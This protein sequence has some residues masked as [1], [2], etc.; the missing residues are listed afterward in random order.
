MEIT[1]RYPFRSLDEFAQFLIQK[2]VIID[3]E[4][5]DSDAYD[6]GASLEKIGSFLS[7]Y[8]PGLL[9]SRKDG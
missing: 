3:C 1:D 2:G 7:G 4:Y 9:V 5:Y 8:D 6:G